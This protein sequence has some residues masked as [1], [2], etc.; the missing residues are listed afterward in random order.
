MTRET[1]LDELPPLPILLNGIYADVFK[2][3]DVLIS[4]VRI[5]DPAHNMVHIR[6]VTDHVR[7]ALAAE[8]LDPHREALLVLAA[9]LHEADDPKLFGTSDDANTRKILSD[10]L[11]SDDGAEGD[12]GATLGEA[13]AVASEVC[14]IISLVSARKNKDA[15]VAPGSEW[16]L[17]VRDADRIEAIG[18]VGIARCYA[19]NQKVGSPLYR[20]TTPRAVTQEELWAIATPARFASYSGDSDSMIDHYY[21][22]LLH[23][24]RCGSGNSYLEAKQQAR[25]QEMIDFVL[26]FG[27]TGEVDV[28]A[29]EAYKDKHCL[30]KDAQRGMK[31]P[32][33][34]IE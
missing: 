3:V 18:E 33:P 30:K 15:G 9:L 4:S 10:C 5:L 2:K 16:K 7:R 32:A 11:T 25:L 22:K 29:L 20:P 19:F 6:A 34:S 31:R 8:P 27:K 17:I 23:L 21:D 26:A 12:T 24:S 28:P 14:E 1:S 13:S